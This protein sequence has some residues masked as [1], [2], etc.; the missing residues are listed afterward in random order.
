MFHLIDFILN[1]AGLLLWL[2]WRSIRFDPALRARPA[3]LA[4]TLRRAEPLRLKRWHFLAG[5]GG[6]L[7]FRAL[8]YWQVGPA[9]YWTPTLDLVVVSLA[10]RGHFFW[11]VLLFSILS[12]ARCALVFFFWLLILAIVN[13]REVEPGALQRLA[14]LHLGR[15]ARWP[16]WAQALAPVFLPA[17]FWLLLHPVLL[18]AGV[19]NPAH[20]WI[21]LAGQGLL[22]G[23]SVYFSLKFLVPAILLLHLVAS[24]VFLGNSPLWDFISTTARNWLKPLNILPLRFGRVDFAPILGIILILLLLHALPNYLFGWLN[25]NNLTIWPQ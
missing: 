10:F 24:Y 14:T 5:L 4:G 19:T 25:R 7:F 8:F 13:R 11:P 18:H 15:A 3:T 22:V 21:Q 1:V 17:A 6:L 16:A 23:I 9:V 12:F 20:G 2:N